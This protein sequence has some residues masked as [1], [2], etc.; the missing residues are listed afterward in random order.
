MQAGEGM[1]R[2]VQRGGESAKSPSLVADWLGSLSW[3]SKS[4]RKYPRSQ[5]KTQDTRATPCT[6]AR[7]VRFLENILDPSCRDKRSILF[8]LS[9]HFNIL[10]MLV[11]SS[12]T[13]LCWVLAAAFRILVVSSVF[14]H[15]DTHTL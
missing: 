2:G 13:R 3:K 15:C 5:K 8:I 9:I 4:L 1:G 6:A 7:G 12:F 14:L 10:C 11:G